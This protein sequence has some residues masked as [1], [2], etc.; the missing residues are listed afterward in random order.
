MYDTLENSAEPGMRRLRTM[1]QEYGEHGFHN[2]ESAQRTSIKLALNDLM[3]LTIR[4]ADAIICTLAAA[5]KVNLAT[6]FHPV[7]VFLDEAARCTELKTNIL[8]GSYAPS[9]FVIAGDHK[10][11][12]PYV[13]SADQWKNTRAPYI[14]PFQNY[15]QL[16]GFERWIMA[17]IPHQLLT[18]QHRCKGDI[19]DWLSKTFYHGQV[20]QAFYTKR[21]KRII[22]DMRE[23]CREKI[24]AAIPTNRYAINI[25]RSRHFKESG[26]TSSINDSEIAHIMADLALMRRDSRFEDKS[27]L[28][29]SFYKAQ[30]TKLKFHCRNLPDVTVL[31]GNELLSK[32]SCNT[33]EQVQGGEFDVVLLSLVNTANPAF[34]NEPHRLLVALSRARFLL[35]IYT[36]WNLINGRTTR[37]N[38]YVKSLFADLA[39]H[40]HVIH[41]EAAQRPNTRI[42]HN[43]QQIGH[44]ARECT[45]PKRVI[46][47]RC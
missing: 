34:V 4:S 2:T 31:D 3:A 37:D 44:P 8:F 21:D 15:T 6:N 43:C 46:C 11:I 28:V 23:F 27:I 33:V 7:I 18:V 29:A 12:R 38:F 32:L 14:N 47:R 36:N 17:G 9:A 5:A 13:G 22:Q 1:L 40:T 39:S 10:Q 24:G 20:R 45:E 19:H 30:V 16:S 35:G 25:D 42:C 41:R 26:D